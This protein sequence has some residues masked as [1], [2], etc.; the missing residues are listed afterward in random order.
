VTSPPP[1]QEPP[2]LEPEPLSEEQREMDK[3]IGVPSKGPIPTLID[4]SQVPVD[5]MPA[6][7]PNYKDYAHPGAP[8][9]MLEL[10]REAYAMNRMEKDIQ[11][12]NV[13]VIG[14][15]GTG[16]TSV[17]RRFSEETGLPYWG[18]QGESTP[19]W[20]L[21]GRTELENGKTVYKPG[22]IPKAVRT[23]GI[24]HFDEINVF[25]PE[26][27]MR[28]DE[29]LDNRRQLNMVNE[30]G[31]VIKAH[32]DLFIIATMNPPTYE[33]VKELPD[34]IKSR[35]GLVVQMNPP[36][37]NDEL[38][39]LQTKFAMSDREFAR[40]KPEVV[41][42]IKAAQELRED[43][44][45][46]YTPTMRESISFLQQ[47]HSGA[48]FKDAAVRALFGKYYTTEE[49]NRVVEAFVRAGHTEFSSL[50]K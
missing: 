37:I 5:H 24:L 20:M 18:V 36:S 25:D 39:A 48:S 42:F 41:A 26:V 10:L 2:E 27:L 40:Y 7:E 23:G 33:G 14:P 29:L 38:N 6:R 32:P 11:P 45:L 47:L 46:S 21:L 17:V 31:E 16:K 13:L 19:S 4:W 30:T 28:L 50:K 22:I 43:Q 3:F 15:K 34:P 12:V 9:G 1:A 35:F 49:R 44:S 8:E